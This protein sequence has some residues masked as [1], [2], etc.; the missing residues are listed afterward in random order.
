MNKSCNILVAEPKGNPWFYVR[1]DLYRWTRKARKA[2]LYVRYYYIE[3]TACMEKKVSRTYPNFFTVHNLWSSNI[4]QFV[5]AVSPKID[6]SGHWSP[7]KV[8]WYK[9]STDASIEKNG[10]RRGLGVVIRNNR[11]ELMGAMATP[12]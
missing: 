8:S 6:R 9:L 1:Y 2:W 4:S 7:S 10:K 3:K 11:G 12:I 5:T